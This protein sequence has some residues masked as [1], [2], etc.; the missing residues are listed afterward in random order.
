MSLLLHQSISL[1]NSSLPT[2]RNDWGG[3][4]PP[5]LRRRALGSVAGPVEVCATD[6]SPYN[7]SMIV[8]DITF[9]KEALSLPA[10]ERAGL[11]RLL[12]ESL[13]GDPRLNEEICKDLQFRFEKLRS[14]VDKGMAFHQ[15]FGE[16]L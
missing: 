14:G 7:D 1:S 16:T 15:V 12:V 10:S 6:Q 8:K 11:V 5:F 4:K 3:W 13:E 2:Y 9:A